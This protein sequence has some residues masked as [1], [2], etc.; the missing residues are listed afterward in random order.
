MTDELDH[1]YLC[2]YKFQLGDLVT[3]VYKI[4]MW[5]GLFKSGDRL[6]PGNRPVAWSHVECIAG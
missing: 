3:G 6:A 1:C 5:L 2:G 4:K